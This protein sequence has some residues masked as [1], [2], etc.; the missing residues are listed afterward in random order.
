MDD[1]EEAHGDVAA[2]PNPAEF[3]GDDDDQDDGSSMFRA[4]IATLALDAASFSFDE[5]RRLAKVR[6]LRTAPRARARG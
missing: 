2:A 5:A 1:G 6:A 4:Q 3:R